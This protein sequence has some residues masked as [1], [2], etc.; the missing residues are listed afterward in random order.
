[1]PL[2]RGITRSVTT[3]DGRNAVI[4]L[5]RLGAVGGRLGREP[6]GAHQ[7][8]QPVRVAGSSSTI[9]TRS[10]ACVRLAHFFSLSSDGARPTTGAAC[11][12]HRK[13]AHCRSLSRSRDASAALRP[14]RP[15]GNPA[16]LRLPHA[17]LPRAARCRPRPRP[18][19]RRLAL[20]ARSSSR[21]RS[22]TRRPAVADLPRSCCGAASGPRDVFLGDRPPCRRRP[23]RACSRC[24]SSCAGRRPFSS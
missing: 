9:S 16:V 1:M 8:G 2:I 13:R 4:M 5:E 18:A 23:A 19:G 12:A 22:P 20:G 7:L 14:G 6:P 17:N 15:G 21:C 10:A 24:P 3:I 11:H